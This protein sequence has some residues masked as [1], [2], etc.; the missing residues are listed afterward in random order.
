MEECGFAGDSWLV[1]LEPADSFSALEMLVCVLSTDGGVIVELLDFCH[2]A[3]QEY[4]SYYLIFSEVITTP[5][6]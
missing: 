3:V 5:G 6:H 1:I 4:G 2:T